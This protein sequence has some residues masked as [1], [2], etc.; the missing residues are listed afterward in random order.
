MDTNGSTINIQYGVS[1]GAGGT[2]YAALISGNIVAKTVSNNPYAGY[3]ATLS[4]SLSSTAYN[5]SGGGIIGLEFWIYGDGNT[6]RVMVH[7]QAVTTGIIT[8]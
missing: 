8:E 3:K 1:P 4:S 6:Y 7:D 2:T 5:L